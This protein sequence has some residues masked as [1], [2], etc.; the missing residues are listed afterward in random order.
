MKLK[1][2]DE[3]TI[4]I[5]G[6]TSGI[7]LTAARLA[8]RRGANVVLVARNEDGLK[9]LADELNS[10]S[11]KCA[12]YYA[13]DV[14]DEESL[15]NAAER[16]NEEFGG[17]D[18]WVN[19]AATGI[20]GRLMDV[21]T[22]DLRRLIETNF[23]GVVNGSKI[24]VRFLSSGG[25]ALI[26]VGSELSETSIPLQGMYSASKHAVK[27]FTESLRMEV[28]ADKL[29]ISVSL[30][31]PA[32][33]HTPFPEN[34]KNYLPYKPRLPAPV[35]APDLAAD[36]ILFCAEN[37]VREI[38]VGGIAKVH[39]AIAAAAPALYE[40]ANEIMIDSMQNSGQAALPNRQDGLYGSNSNLRERG[41]ADR[42][43]RERSA[44]QAA[45]KHPIVSA[46]LVFAASLATAALIG[47]RTKSSETKR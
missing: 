14:A 5:T 33:I 47:S 37:S 27:A 40:K 39:T 36:A 10:D 13:A 30:I 2:I 7:G 43:V 28:E 42:F 18:T 32:A 29:P 11:R 3:Q 1:K 46:G 8:A 20:Y 41:S 17:F 23:W 34:A 16:A 31:K 19:N 38:F 26:N 25:G 21:P 22:E 12:I 6:A 4:V 24:A 15:K 45:R 35:Y 44:Y 9:K